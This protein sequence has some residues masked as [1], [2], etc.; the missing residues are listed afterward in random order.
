MDNMITGLVER[1]DAMVKADRIRVPSS[2]RL[3][4]YDNV[5]IIMGRSRERKAEALM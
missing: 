2:N 4:D 3:H 5:V 1:A